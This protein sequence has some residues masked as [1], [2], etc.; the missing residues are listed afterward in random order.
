MGYIRPLSQPDLVGPDVQPAIDLPAVGRNDLT[1][2]LAGKLQRNRRL[3][4][5]GGTQDGD[6][7]RVGHD[8]ERD[9]NFP[10]SWH[11][12]LARYDRG[13]TEALN[14][15]GVMVMSS[16]YHWLNCWPS[17]W[18]T[19]P[20]IWVVARLRGLMLSATKVATPLVTSK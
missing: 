12:W 18:F 2:E 8:G 3:A 1:V 11:L 5:G 20:G 10:K 15:P 13:L 6:Q 4:H 7:R 19:K 14:W 17:A 16:T 9:A